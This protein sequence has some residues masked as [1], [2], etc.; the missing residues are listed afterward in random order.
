LNFAYKNSDTTV[1][2]LSTKKQQ[3]SYLLKKFNEPL[4]GEGCQNVNKHPS[5][6]Y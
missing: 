4:C 3:N 1:Y 2:I 6:L 5:Y